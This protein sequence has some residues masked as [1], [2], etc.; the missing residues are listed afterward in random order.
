MTGIALELVALDEAP[1]LNDRRVV[2]IWCLL[3]LFR[4]EDDG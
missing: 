2:P 3:I 4:E 1:P